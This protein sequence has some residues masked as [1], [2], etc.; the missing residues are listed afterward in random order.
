MLS[1]E[2]A[3]GRFPVEAIQ[4]MARIAMATEASRR[5]RKYEPDL[6]LVPARDIP[7]AISTAANAI[8]GALCVKAIIAFTQ[9]GNTARL[10]SRQRPDVPIMAFTPFEEVYHRLN[11]LWGVVP[12]FCP[13]NESMSYL[14]N[15][16]VHTLLKLK[17]ISPGEMIA[18]TGGYPIAARGITNFLH[19]FEV[20]DPA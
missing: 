2:T 6:S 12:F 13:Y 9:S 17:L 16:A 5:Y 10:V 19:I 11:L 20:I 1:G 18:I 15:Y 7:N 3:A 14:I 8:V 4:M